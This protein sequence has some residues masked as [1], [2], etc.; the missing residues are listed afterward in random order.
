MSGTYAEVMRLLV[1]VLL[2]G[3]VLALIVGL[4]LLIV[5]RSIVKLFSLN[6]VHPLSVRRA[7]KSLEIPRDSE[8]VMLRYPR[9]LGGALL[10]G[11]IFVLIKWGMFV[12]SLNVKEGGQ[13]LMRFYANT[14]WPAPVWE[15]LWLS[16]LVLILLGALFAILMGVLALVKVQTLKNLS[17]FTNRWISTRQ[18][19]KPAARPYYGIDRFVATHPQAL[20]GII[21]LLS[22]YALVMILW[23][24]GKVFM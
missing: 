10:A 12:S 6:S 11:G 13:T 16:V 18:A 3:N 9:V 21:S 1:L 4:S 5:P 20:G 24:G 15:S 14:R 17:D 7:T 22:V 19:A 2:I 8:K 23:F